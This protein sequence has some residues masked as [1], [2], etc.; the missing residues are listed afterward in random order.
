MTLSVPVHMYIKSTG[1][2]V[3]NSWEEIACT[4]MCVCL[5]LFDMLLWHMQRDWSHC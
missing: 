1:W 5:A 3:R 4:H 2:S